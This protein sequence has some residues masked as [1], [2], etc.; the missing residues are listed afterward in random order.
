MNEETIKSLLK[1]QLTEKRYRHS[2]A[3][4]EAA[5]QLAKRYGADVDKARF[6]GLVHDIC[7]D[8]TKDMQLQRAEEFAII[9]TESEQ[10]C[11]NCGML[12]L[13]QVM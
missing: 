6:A 7:K 9:L 3:V 11:P 1:K 2:L 13:V 5:V 8:E 4:S 12:L 10:L